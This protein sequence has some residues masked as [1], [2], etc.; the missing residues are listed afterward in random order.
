MLSD[1]QLVPLSRNHNIYHVEGL[2]VGTAFQ[3]PLQLPCLDIGCVCRCLGTTAVTMFRYWQCM[4]LSWNHNSCNVQ[5]LVVYAAVLEPQ[6]LPCL[7]IGSVC[8]CL[9]ITAV[10]MFRYWQCMPLSWNHSSCN[11]EGLVFDAAVLEPQQ[12]PCL[13][14]GSVCRCLGTTTF[15]VLRDQQLIPLSWNQYS[16]HVQILVVYAAVLESQHLPCLDIGSACRCLGTTTVTMFR[17]WQLMPLSWNHN[18]YHVQ[19]LVVD[20]AVLEPQH[21]PC[22]DI[23]SVCR[24]LG[25]TTFTMFRYWQLMP[26]SWNH[27]IYHV[28]ILVVHAAVLEPQQFPCLDI[29]S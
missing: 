29:G 23:G 1:Q 12:L 14:I 20:A 19:I 15:A 13:D 7:D 4:P 17:Y 9:G 8:R 26:L 2:V 22:L 16:Y 25:T 24:C 10:A 18:S 27:N 21:L 5:I 28:Q 11:V 3:E 6:Q